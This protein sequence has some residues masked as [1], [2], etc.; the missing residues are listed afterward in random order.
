[1]IWSIRA[2]IWKAGRGTGGEQSAFFEDE[3]DDDDV[4]KGP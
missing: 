3:G 2:L 1:M 4:N